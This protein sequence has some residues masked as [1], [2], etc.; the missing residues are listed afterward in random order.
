LTCVREDE[1]KFAGY[2]PKMPYKIDK[3]ITRH[4]ELKP[5]DHILFRHTGYDHHAIVVEVKRGKLTVIGFSGV[6][7]S[8][9]N[10][11]A[12]KSSAILSTALKNY[13]IQQTTYTEEEFA[14]EE[15]YLCKYEEE[16]CDDAVVERA[17][18]VEKGVVAWGGY[19][20]KSNNCEHFA[21]W[22]KTG[23]K[24]SKQVKTAVESGC[25]CS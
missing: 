12:A 21:T 1:L 24:C 8:A 16:N 5:G 14:K 11:S 19:D 22:C 4:T 17:W 2:N 23:V 10:L 3:R 13:K 6:Q 9:L 25:S 7:S 15:V 20:L 18:S